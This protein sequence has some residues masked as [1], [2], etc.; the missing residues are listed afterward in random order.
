M[1]VGV[2]VAEVERLDACADTSK[3]WLYSILLSN[4]GEDIYGFDKIERSC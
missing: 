4:G 3:G 1:M 2:L